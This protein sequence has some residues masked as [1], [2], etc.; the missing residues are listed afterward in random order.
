MGSEDAPR[1]PGTLDYDEGETDK[2]PPPNATSI[3]AGSVPERP[4]NLSA[5]CPPDDESIR[6]PCRRASHDT[7]S[8]L[9]F[10]LHPVS[11]SRG[12]RCGIRPEQPGQEQ[13]SR[14]TA[15]SG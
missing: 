10:S 1:I 3:G 14:Q 11:H 13:R 9:R 2:H 8:H 15:E 5:R 7:L 4:L 6:K 12:L